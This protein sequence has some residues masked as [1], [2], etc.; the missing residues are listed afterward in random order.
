[1]FRESYKKKQESQLRTIFIKVTFPLNSFFFI[2]VFKLL[3][4]VVPLRDLSEIMYG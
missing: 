2:Y 4:A 1:M 3:N